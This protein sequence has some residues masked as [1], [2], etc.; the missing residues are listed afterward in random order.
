[1][2]KDFMMDILLQTM[3][4]VRREDND[5]NIQELVIES[6]E[7]INIQAM[8]AKKAEEEETEMEEEEDEERN[9]RRISIRDIIKGI[10]L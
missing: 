5:G 7:Y 6:Y 8:A 1:M 3:F 10:C 2:S 9:R 4:I